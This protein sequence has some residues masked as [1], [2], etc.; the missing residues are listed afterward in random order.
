MEINK[1]LII[2]LLSV[3]L[4][5][6]TANVFYD[7]YNSIMIKNIVTINKEKPTHLEYSE[8]YIK[9]MKF[10]THFYIFKYI[11][12]IV[13]GIWLFYEAKRHKQSKTIWTVIGIIFGILG[14]ILFYVYNIFYK[15][16]KIKIKKSIIPKRQ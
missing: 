5:S 7:A 13:I 12:M 16:I 14:V 15:N 1:K 9:M 6:I 10:I 4:L 11:K 3:F 2:I 8:K